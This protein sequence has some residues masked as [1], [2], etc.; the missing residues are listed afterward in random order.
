MKHIL[1]TL[2]I[3]KNVLEALTDTEA[4]HYFKLFVRDL[5]SFMNE[6]EQYTEARQHSPSL[7]T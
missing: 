4:K 7:H 5:L 3:T 1:I 2:C 6:K